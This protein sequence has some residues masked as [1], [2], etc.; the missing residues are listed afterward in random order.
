MALRLIEESSNSLPEVPFLSDWSNAKKNDGNTYTVL[1]VLISAKGIIM[2][3]SAFKVF[4][5]KSEKLHNVLL[6]HIGSSLNPDT[7]KDSVGVCLVA[8]TK[9]GFQVGFDDEVLGHWESEGTV[10]S[11]LEASTALS[12]TPTQ[13]EIVQAPVDTSPKNARRA[14]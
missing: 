12:S 8:S 6:E 10:Y 14:R 2:F 1:S 7:P 13:T 5:W 3:T 9:K 4:V 11:F